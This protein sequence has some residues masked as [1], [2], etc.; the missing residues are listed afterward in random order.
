MNTV[1]IT[2]N[3][4]RLE[5]P[6]EL[7]ILDAARAQG[8]NIPTLC[9]MQGAGR[10]TSCMLCVVHE[11]VTDRLLPSCSAPVTEGM[12][13]ETEN[14]RVK[15]ARRDALD[16]LLSEHVGDCDA[17]CQRACPAQMDIPLMIRQIKEQQL[18]AA[19]K[20]V[21]RNIALPAVLGRI[22]PAPCEKGC[23]R[24]SHD[25]P[26]A[27]CLLKRYV[28]D[29]DLAQTSPYRPDVAEK[30]GKK[31]AIVGAGPCGLAAA[32]YLQQKGHSCSLFDKNRHAGG[33]LRYG[34]SEE[35]LPRSV[36]EAEIDQVAALGADF[37][38]ERSLG[39]DVAFDE[40]RQEYDV[41]VLAFGSQETESAIIPGIES[42]IRGI[43]VDKDTYATNIR[44][45]FAGGNAV[46]PSQMAVRAV[47]HGRS[48][49]AAAHQFLGGEE[50][51]GI[52]RRFNSIM[53]K[54]KPGEAA[55]F[56]WEADDRNRIEPGGG[57]EA[58]FEP[59]EAVAEASRCF[60]CDCRKPDTCKLRRFADGYA[61]D[62][63]RYRFGEKKGFEKIVQHDM[64]V[65]EPGK[66]IKC[67]LCV[68]ITK[69]AGEEYGLTFVN[70]GF[71]VR[72]ETPFREP[73]QRGLQ[74]TARE[75]V[76]TCPTGAL[77]WLDRKR[78]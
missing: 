71:E 60:G 50:V 20:T 45:V 23:K 58:G 15:E 14:L 3:D 27:I 47:A 19:I 42:T 35:K 53:G 18:E 21:K 63:S 8:I 17:P 52:P 6:A 73:L 4:R 78:T 11:L 49:A 36:L 67:G 33:Q 31:V 64:V 26:L 77:S 72:V 43:A 66:C 22:C 13:I 12:R 68:Q 10:F 55:E 59:R 25:A 37:F 54:L 30:S 7:T 28:A 74:K 70:R 65:Y 51:S 9:F 46:S 62:Q 75:C 1:T 5:V 16:F 24:R 32:Y 69:R 48:I 38:L 76:E 56:L 2:L 29:T 61:A 40:L 44:G 34:V 41:L 57:Q 39:M